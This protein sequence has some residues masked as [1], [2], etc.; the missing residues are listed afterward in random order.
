M[1]QQ[2]H[3]NSSA[4]ESSLESSSGYGSQTMPMHGAHEDLP[5]P[6]GMSL[7]PVCD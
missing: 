4:S 5:H 7:V 6:D 2:E 1:F 3:E